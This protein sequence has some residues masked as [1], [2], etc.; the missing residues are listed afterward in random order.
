MKQI[1]SAFFSLL[2]ILNAFSQNT[3]GA[4]I[5]ESSTSFNGKTAAL[6]IGISDYLEIEPLQFADKDAEIF[7]QFLLSSSDINVEENDLKI[8]T[9][10]EATIGNIIQSLEWL[11]STLKEGDRFIFYFAGHGDVETLT[12]ANNGY[13]LLNNTPKNVY[14]AGGL[15]INVLKDYF[16]TLGN[17]GVQIIAIIDACKSGT[18]AGGEA[19]TEAT[20]NY[21]QKQ[22]NEEI[23]I[24]SS[25]PGQVSLESEKWGGGRGLFSYMLL[26]GL[27]GKAD[28]DQNGEISVYEIEAFIGPKIVTESKGQQEPIVEC[29]KKFTTS[30]LSPNALFANNSI[31]SSNSDLIA[32]RGLNTDVD[33]TSDIY[34]YLQQFEECIKNDSLEGNESVYASFWV[35]KLKEVPSAN[36]YYNYAR[37]TLGGKL[38]DRGQTIINEYLTGRKFIRKNEF[39]TASQD[40]QFAWNYLD[41]SML[42]SDDLLAKKYFLQAA[43][44]ADVFSERPNIPKILNVAIPLLDKAENL[45]PGSAYI[46]M[47]KAK[48]YYMAN[49]I[50]KSEKFLQI[51]M[52]RSPGWVMPVYYMGAINNV[53]GKKKKA[54]KYLEMALEMDTTLSSF[55]CTP[56]VLLELGNLMQDNKN[57]TKAEFYFKLGLG[58]S[59]DLNDFYISLFYL[60][61]DTKEFDKADEQ[62]ENL[63]A[64]FTESEIEN[65]KAEKMIAEGK[66]E[67]AV[68]Y[69]QELLEKYPEDDDAAI[70]L[71]YAFFKNK[72]VQDYYKFKNYLEIAIDRNTDYCFA[73]TDLVQLLNREKR[74]DESVVV[75]KK[76]IEILTNV[77]ELYELYYLLIE[78]AYANN[79]D[80]SVYNSLK[81]FIENNYMY[82]KDLENY[83][84]YFMFTDFEEDFQNLVSEYCQEE[85]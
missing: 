22:W 3:R 49:E 2:F 84:E 81:F 62:I 8:L 38:I 55:Q 52:K 80:E 46:P 69:L 85:E 54:G 45:Q 60:F 58:L 77:D 13:L 5:A 47:M 59:P 56:C 43:S 31:G 72:K 51:A 36:S 64:F 34:F 79:D 1:L 17:K 63:K 30:F 50:K 32:Q 41:E 71:A 10:E 27:T 24:L 18:L 7:A 65:L 42:N 19:G 11:K 15:P 37:L 61:L 16:T 44:V 14:M 76:G 73:Y 48:L 70:N 25:Q 23:K 20:L 74:F 40:F 9:N 83:N 21:L 28:L 29:Q 68:V 39:Y 33:T 35:Q 4:K 12:D 75:L 6:I 82:C 26:E 78:S 53:L 66:V 67:E 57:Y